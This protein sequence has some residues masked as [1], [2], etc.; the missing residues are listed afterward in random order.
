M[1]F[2]GYSDSALPP[3]LPAIQQLNEHYPKRAE[4]VFSPAPSSSV[5]MNLSLPGTIKG[6]L[7]E[8]FP[9]PKEAVAQR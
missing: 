3:M 9:V 6:L 4:P 2:F 1:N 8:Q 7:H 5:Q